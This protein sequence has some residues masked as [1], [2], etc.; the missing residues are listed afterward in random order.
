MSVRGVPAA[1]HAASVLKRQ[2]YSGQATYF[3][4]G[5][6]ACGWT[7]VDSDHIVAL[8]T[9]DYDG[10]AHCGATVSI[11]DSSGTSAT[12]T[13][14]DECP[15]CSSGDLDMSPSLFQVFEDLSVGV[16]PITWSF[17]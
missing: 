14:A 8:A 2:T 4:V 7:S 5:L 1:P 13:V 9:P 12:A 17:S 10:G 3:E 6:G 15:S 16:F 11:S